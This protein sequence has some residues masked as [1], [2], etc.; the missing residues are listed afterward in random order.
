VNRFIEHGYTSLFLAAFGERL[1]VPLLVTPVIVAAGLLA[2]NGK[3]DLLAVIAVVT[4]AT[5]LGDWLWFQ[6]GRRRGSR[7]ANFLCRVSLSRDSCVRRTQAL[8]A[9]H[10]GT[11]LLYAKWIPGVAHLSSPMAGSSGMSPVRFTALNSIGTF[12]WVVTLALTG[13]ISM[14]PLEWSDL[15]A[16][17]FGMLPLWLLIIFL[18]NGAWKYVQ[19]RRFI[20]SLRMARITPQELFARLQ[21]AEDERPIIIDLRH[22]LDVLADPRTIPGALNIL[23]EDIEQYA[24]NLPLTRE[25]VLVCT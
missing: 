17:V 23:P 5:L 11:L 12:V 7:I 14:R 2:A 10:A 24:K 1:G 22:P 18:V 13:W 21:S 3:L 15:A 20:R 8:S 9:R 6:L 19:R 25:F 4:F 16:A